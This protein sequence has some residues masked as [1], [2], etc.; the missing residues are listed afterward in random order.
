V[1][2]E[3]ANEMTEKA[4]ISYQLKEHEAAKAKGELKAVS[5]ELEM[6]T[7]SLNTSIKERDAAL[8]SLEQLNCVACCDQRA[9]I[10]F[11]CGH[12][13]YCES[14]DKVAIDKAIDKTDLHCPKCRHPA[15]IDT[16]QRIFVGH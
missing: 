16:H 13:P 6:A 12:V 1:K 9:I 3:A 7:S 10:K 5:K 8:E 2:I 4:I 14:C 11:P 15:S